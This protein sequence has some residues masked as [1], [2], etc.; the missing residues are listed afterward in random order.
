[1][2]VFSLG[3]KKLLKNSKL[4]DR[5]GF[6]IILFVCLCIV[7]VT[8]VYM[9]KY[10]AN[11][12][13]KIAANTAKS[14]KNPGRSTDPVLTLKP[15]KNVTQPTSKQN[16]KSTKEVAL[17]M[18]KARVKTKA[19]STAKTKAVKAE[20]SIDF[21]IIYPVKGEIVK[22]Y[23]NKELQKSI[24]L[25]QWETHE[26]IDIACE[27]GSEVKA[28]FSGKILEVIVNDK[29][30]SET[31]KNG[32]GASITIDHG[33]GYK[34]IYANLASE[35]LKLKKGDIVKV[36][37]VIG[38]VG[39]TSRREDVAMEGSHLHFEVLKKVGKEYISVNPEQFLK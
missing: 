25:N 3:H 7:A 33:D 29:N 15:D 30:F 5:E 12:S 21:K 16:V 14:K 24:A 1:M 2:E 34:T 11:T 17:E 18:A 20:Q 9:S 13:Q 37:D 39:D 28:A 36:G 19:S 35:T 4:F 38:N 22:K 6:Y 23:D 10:N 27:L 31:E 8:A 32:F 26:G